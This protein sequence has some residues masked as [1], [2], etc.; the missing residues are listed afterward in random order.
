MTPTQAER[1]PMT[2]Y[3]VIATLTWKFESDAGQTESLAYAK[4]Q[5][6][7]I[8]DTNPHGHDFDGFSVQVDLAVLKDRK[9]LVHLAAFE[10]DEVF[11]FV[12]VGDTKRDYTVGDVTYR[13]RMNSDRYHLFMANPACVYCGLAGTKMVLDMNPSDASPHFN[14]YAEEAGRLVLMT[15]DHVLAKSKG[16][17]DEL[18]NYVTCCSTCNNLKGAY[19]LGP[20]Q[21]RELRRLYDNGDKLPRKEL[22]VLINTRREELALLNATKEDA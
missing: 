4:S 6:E 9:R 19:P 14:M 13:V 20:D 5:L 10:L 12:T 3:K 16:G 7:D 8:L 2:T 1:K 18:A 22:R 11:P 21:V 17:R 15:K